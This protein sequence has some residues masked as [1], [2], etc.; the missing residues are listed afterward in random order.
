[1]EEIID[2]YKFCIYAFFKKTLEENPKYLKKFPSKESLGAA[3]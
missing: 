1:M 3:F 2:F